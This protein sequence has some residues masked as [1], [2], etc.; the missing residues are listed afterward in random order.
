MTEP[1]HQKSGSQPLPESSARQ[2][3]KPGPRASCHQRRDE[4]RTAGVGE[5]AA[6]RDPGRVHSGEGAPRSGGT[7]RTPGLGPARGHRRSGA[8]A[9]R[10]RGR[11]GRGWSGWQR[12]PAARRGLLHLALPA[13]RGHS[14]PAG[15]RSQTRDTRGLVHVQNM[16]AHEA[17]AHSTEHTLT[18][19]CVCNSAH[20]RG[21]RR[22]QDTCCTHSHVH[23]HR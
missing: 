15:N 6:P 11:P 23:S 20:R 22:S 5:R 3:G 16:H 7:S 14:R 8:D 12:T 21:T 18:W 9:R 13:R 17:N 4:G 19:V 2:G 10:A 1:K